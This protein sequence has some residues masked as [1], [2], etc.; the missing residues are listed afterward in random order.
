MSVF[1]PHSSPPLQTREGHWVYTARVVKW[2][3]GDTVVVDCM[4]DVGFEEMVT[5]RRRI[6]LDGDINCPETNR[7]ASRE[8]GLAAR[9]YSEELAPAES[10][11]VVRVTRFDKYGGRDD[12]FVVTPEGIDVSTALLAA[13]HAVVKDY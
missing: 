3:D 5:K 11:V 1:D 4:V 8:A 2:T 7:A 10:V 13:G 12:G 6:R 9:A